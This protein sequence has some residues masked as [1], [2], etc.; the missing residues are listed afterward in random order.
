MDQE[1]KHLVITMSD[2]EYFP[3]GEYFVKTRNRIDADF[4][5]YTPTGHKGLTVLETITLRENDI[6]VRE[7]DCKKFYSMMQTLKFYYIYWNL[8]DYEYITFC[9]FDTYFVN[10]W[11]SSVFGK[12]QLDF[13]LGITTT[14][15]FPQWNYLRSKA[16]GG[17]IFAK[18]KMGLTII[19]R[20]LLKCISLG[21]DKYL[22][23][24]D[25]IWKTLED[26]K[27]GPTKQKFRTDFAWWCDQVALSALVLNNDIGGVKTFPCK[28]YNVL[29]SAWSPE[30]E[31]GVYIKHLK[32]KNRLVK[33]GSCG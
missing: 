28:Q 10:D 11:K 31:P 3:N 27:R 23:E 21:E 17:V 4:L 30:V 7:I 18:D 26:P 29:E 5:L 15:G 32:G 22:P 33:G 14:K 20:S 12:E 8:L 13:S 6:E 24:Y 16:N 9:D 1:K 25:K 2:R 19:L